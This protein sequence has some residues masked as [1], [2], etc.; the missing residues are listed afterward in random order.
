M[1]NRRILV[2]FIASFPHQ[3]ANTFLVSKLIVKNIPKVNKITV[4]VSSYGKMNEIE[5]FSDTVVPSYPQGIHSKISS[6][7][8][9][10]WTMYRLR[11]FYAHRYVKKSN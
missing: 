11:F 2:G 7:C 10:P 3:Q 8:L 4:M 5:L 1:K 9:K 6:R